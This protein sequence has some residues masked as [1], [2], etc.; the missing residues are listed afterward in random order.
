MY[1]CHPNEEMYQE[2]E[3]GLQGED[4]GSATEQ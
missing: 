1:A 2:G 3:K 4:E